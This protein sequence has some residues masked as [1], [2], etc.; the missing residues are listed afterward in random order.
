M[1][2]AAR[3]GLSGGGA[4]GSFGAVRTAYKHD[5]AKQGE[6]RAESGEVR[7]ESGMVSVVGFAGCL[8]ACLYVL[9]FVLFAFC[10]LMVIV[11]IVVIAFG[12]YGAGTLRSTRERP[13]R[14]SIRQAAIID[15]CA[16]HQQ[17][18]SLC[19]ASAIDAWRVAHR[20]G[21]HSR[22]SANL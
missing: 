5:T 14:F 21:A 1:R 12:A 22:P 7:A 19:Y 9:L 15:Q 13:G 2:G 3:V 16:G 18:F 11:A 4:S 8:I 10:V 17:Q 20:C 6:V